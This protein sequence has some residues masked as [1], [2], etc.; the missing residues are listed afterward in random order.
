MPSSLMSAFSLP[1]SLRRSTVW[2]II[3]NQFGQFGDGTTVD[4][5]TTPVQMSSVTNAVRTAAGYY[6]NYVL[7]ADSTVL[8]VGSS[9]NGLLGE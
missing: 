8:A 3:N 7:L 5:Y 9:Y 6:A 4:N 1:V 2:S